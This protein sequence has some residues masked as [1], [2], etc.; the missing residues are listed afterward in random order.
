MRSSSRYTRHGRTR[1]TYISVRSLHL[2]LVPCWCLFCWCGGNANNW[3]ISWKI[4]VSFKTELDILSP[5]QKSIRFL[6]IGW[7]SNLV[8]WPIWTWCPEH[9]TLFPLGQTHFYNFLSSLGSIPPCAAIAPISLSDASTIVW[10]HG[11]PV[12]LL[13]REKQLWFVFC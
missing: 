13:V 10:L 4:V 7:L 12:L 2:L 3:C 11:C 9:F 1:F 6:V 8:E 5:W